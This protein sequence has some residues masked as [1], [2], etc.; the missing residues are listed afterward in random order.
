[1]PGALWDMLLTTKMAAS[2]DGEKMEKEQS[3]TFAENVERTQV[4]SDN[5]NRVC[6]IDSAGLYCIF[7]L[8][9][10]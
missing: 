7:C 5:K 1:M 4:K 2:S 9:M 10:P 6:V 8:F 3:I